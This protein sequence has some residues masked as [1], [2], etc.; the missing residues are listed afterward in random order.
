MIC[1]VSLNCLEL[2]FLEINLPSTSCTNTV[3][4]SVV[5]KYAVNEETSQNTQ[6]LGHSSEQVRLHTLNLPFL[7]KFGDF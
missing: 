6:F 1:L 5:A 7:R 3:Q 4:V 2:K